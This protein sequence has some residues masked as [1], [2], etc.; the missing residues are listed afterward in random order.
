MTSGLFQNG[1][2][3]SN[4]IIYA[5]HH[6]RASQEKPSSGDETIRA[7]MKR[8]HINIAALQEPSRPPLVRKNP[9][10]FKSIAQVS[11]GFR[12]RKILIPILLCHELQRGRAQLD[13]DI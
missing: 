8:K 5:Q 2:D 7:R 11:T 3:F 12:K 13:D 9:L 10:Q 1:F 4:Q 6:M